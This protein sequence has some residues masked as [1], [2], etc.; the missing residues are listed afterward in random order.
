[1]KKISF[2]ALLAGFLIFNHFILAAQRSSRTPLNTAQT[3]LNPNPPKLVVGIVVDQMRYDYLSRFWN[4]YGNDGFKRLVNQGY[5][6]DNNHFNYIPTYTAPGHASIYT[7]TTP[8]VHGII[9]NQWYDKDSDSVVYCVEDSNYTSV[10][11]STTAG[12][13]SPKWMTVSTLSDQMRLH[14]QFRGKTIA[15]SMKDRGA[16]LPGGH[17]ADGAYWFAGG[18]EGKWITSSF[19]MDALPNWVK[20]Y[21][22]SG[23]VAGYLKVWSPLKDIKTY[24]ESGPDNNEFE[25]TFNGESAPV[26]P[27]DLPALWNQNSGFELLKV[28]P[29]GNSITT[30][31]AI[32][33]LTAEKLG[34]DNYMDMLAISYSSTDYVGHFYGANSKEI[35]DTYIRLD[36]DI[37]RLLKALDKEV[38]AGEYT[39]F[40]TADHGA[41]HV[42]AYLKENKIPAGYIQTAE[43]TAKI[44]EFMKYR[45]GTDL[46]KNVSNWQ[47]FLDHEVISNLS[48]NLRDVQEELALQYLSYPNI[49]RVFTGYQMQLN[50]PDIG[51]PAILQNGYH[52]KRSGDLLI[53]PEPGFIDY[54]VKGSTHGSA[55]TYDTHVP[56]IFFGKGI[57]KGQSDR[58]TVISDIAPTLAALLGIALPNASTGAPIPSVLR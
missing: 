26:F 7:G 43:M 9:S 27:H 52:Q 3:Q 39:V 14:T 22:S 10:G 42:P 50:V 51:L 33:A 36:L 11:T 21:N 5:S 2:L 29:F 19:Y 48:L 28:S 49:D 32:E 1:M 23:K 41:V 57:N 54:P 16:I 35:Q 25:Q 31:F 56:L 24:I 18:S 58:K 30:D 12:Q 20:R 37:A 6:C 4:H 44:R 13:M 8:S 47:V 15:I 38:G 34:K 45:Y 17:S 46:L 55:Q 53:V 40:L